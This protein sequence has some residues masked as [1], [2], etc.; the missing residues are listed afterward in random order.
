MENMCIATVGRTH[1]L[2]MCAQNVIS[3]YFSQDQSGVLSSQQTTTVPAKLKIQHKCVLNNCNS[4]Y[5]SQKTVIF[6][7]SF[8]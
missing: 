3:I 4:L 1:P 6:N 8:P 5:D 7:S 2:W